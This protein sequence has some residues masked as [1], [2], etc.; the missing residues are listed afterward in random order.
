LARWASSCRSERC[1]AAPVTVPAVPARGR[2]GLSGQQSM[3]VH[4]SGPKEARW[5]S[6]MKKVDEVGCH[7]RK[8]TPRVGGLSSKW[9]SEEG[10]I[11]PTRASFCCTMM[12]SATWDHERPASRS[13]V[14]QSSAVAVKQC[15]DASPFLGPDRAGS[16]QP[17]MHHPIYSGRRLDDLH[18]VI[19]TWGY[20]A[21]I[22]VDEK[23][24]P[25]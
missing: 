15:Y 12:R 21:A 22:E 16:T 10:G 4:D 7:V 1:V 9:S 24:V 13:S 11:E 3:P 23:R 19:E 17:S 14:Q 18:P 2:S 6:A 20:P 8:V 5:L 25:G